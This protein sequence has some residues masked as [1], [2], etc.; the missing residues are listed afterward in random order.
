MVTLF[1]Y[2]YRDGG[3]FQAFG[4]VVLKGA[5]LPRELEKLQAR[6]SGDGLFIAE[7]LD[8]PPLYE[9][10]YRW[11]NGPI[12]SDHCW[13][14][15]IDVRAVN[16]SSL[17]PDTVVW[18]DAGAFLRRVLSIVTWNEELSPHFRLASSTLALGRQL[19][20]AIPLNFD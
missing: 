16:K 5:L 15:F 20:P 1:E 10:L 18:G 9:V 17:P 19:R 6:F 12:V 11:S 13:H 4:T 2:R 7:E 3:N 8:I 14:E